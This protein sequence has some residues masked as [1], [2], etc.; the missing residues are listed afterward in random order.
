MQ[1][2][3]DRGRPAIDAPARHST[4]QL[5]AQTVDAILQTNGFGGFL[6]NFDASEHAFDPRYQLMVAICRE[7]H[8][9]P[10][11]TASQ[12]AEWLADGVMAERFQNHRGV[13]KSPRAQATIIGS[14][15]ADYLDV[16]LTVDGHP[17]HLLRAYP[18]GPTRSA[19]YCFSEAER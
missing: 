11:A 10:A 1:V 3:V 5:W 13:V 16:E 6:S 2:W 7:H 4:S 9:K 14:L 17:Y 18:N 8:D 12:W 15:F 19:L